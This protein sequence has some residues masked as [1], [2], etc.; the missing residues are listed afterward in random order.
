MKA[1]LQRFKNSGKTD[2]LLSNSPSDPNIS[3]REKEK[4]DLPPLRQW[5]PHPNQDTSPKSFNSAKPLPPI[6]RDPVS[7]SHSNSQTSTESRSSTAR[8]PQSSSTALGRTTHSYDGREDSDTHAVKRAE[9]P[10]HDSID[11]ASITPSSRANR[12]TAD[13][14][15]SDAAAQKKVAFLSPS[16]T[17]EP[18]TRVLSADSAR[19]YSRSRDAGDAAVEDMDES[20]V[21][22]GTSAG[23]NAASSHPAG[24]GNDVSG[25]QKPAKTSVS[26]FQAA[27]GSEMRSGGGSAS[28]S[29]V[30]VS[31][32]MN[33]SSIKGGRTP[34]S[35]NSQKTF[36]DNAS[37]NAS[38]RSNT[39]Y[40][41]ASAA[42]SRIL[43]TASWSE[44]AEDDL[45]SNIGPR[46]RT[47]QEV[48]W[49]IVA[50]E[51]RYVGVSMLCMF[52]IQ[53]HYS[54]DTSTN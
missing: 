34:I 15:A 41:Q 48:L 46:E 9:L 35:P 36:G 8:A 13:N 42:S 21:G 31:K 53:A 25:T 19:S 10:R 4:L 5:P 18:L 49:E 6:D 22:G 11:G 3:S 45:V 47:R 52:G 26:R 40:S 28:S 27:H 50:S 23:R 39:P 54:T 37:M 20:F 17:P 51:D 16:T 29:R 44:A 7:L 24:A 30:N 43:A 33:G 1:L 32:G 38:M 14:A 12:K 2:K